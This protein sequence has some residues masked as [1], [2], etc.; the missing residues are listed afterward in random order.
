M[1]EITHTSHFPAPVKDIRALFFPG[2]VLVAA[3]AAGVFFNLYAAMVIGLI[4][5]VLPYWQ[6][7]RALIL[8]L[9]ATLLWPQTLAWPVG[10][11]LWG[12]S[13]IMF[14]ALVLTWVFAWSK[15]WVALR[16]TPLDLPLLLFIAVLF[17]SEVIISSGMTADQF[18]RSIKVIG[19]TLV[20]WFALYY[21]VTSIATSKKVIQKI[22]GIMIVLISIVALVGVIEYL[23]GVRVFEWLRL[24][25]PGGE[26]MRSNIHEQL[27]Q[28]KLW[29]FYRGGI[30]RIVSTT[31]S[32]HEVGTL[33]VMTLPLVIY[34]IA[35]VRSW[36]QRLP[37]MI[38][39]GLIVSALIL[40]VTRGAMLASIIVILCISLFSKKGLLRATIILM[41]A[42]VIIAI[43]I[44]PNLSNVLMTV[45]SAGDISGDTSIYTRAEDW[46]E[47]FRLIQGHELT[48]LGP[49]LVSGQK[50]VGY[51]TSV[52]QSFKS[53]DNFYLSTFAETGILGIASLIFILSSIFAILIRRRR[54]SASDSGDEVYDLQIALLSSSVGFMF[55][56]F[57]F[58]AFNFMTVTKYFWVIVGL[59]MALV[60]VTKK[61]SE[62]NKTR[63]IL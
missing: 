60:L 25:L 27:L 16:N 22:I 51:G 5:I 47:A 56:S 24:Y 18:S 8:F 12:P 26:S 37:C 49:G 13:R 7:D 58:S 30:V 63:I 38:S 32:P 20:E 41:A 23:T 61:N 48:G 10:P 40:S 15:G 43:T 45:S 33:M 31:I 2:T 55:M 1:N 6:L 57:T 36:R 39:L 17:I 9:A 3:L 52:S 50:L 46:P 19:F 35:Y 14:L 53:T 42:S 29:A 34:F 28:K 54:L 4:A 62:R 11:L 59:G 44:F 21:I